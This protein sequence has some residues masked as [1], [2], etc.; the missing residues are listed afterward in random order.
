MELLSGIGDHHFLNEF[1]RQQPA[2]ATD[3]GTVYVA[4]RGRDNDLLNIMPVNASTL[5]PDIGHDFTQSGL[6]TDVGPAL[7]S[8]NGNDLW[9]AWTDSDDHIKIDEVDVNA[10][11]SLSLGADKVTVTD[12][13]HGIEESTD[14]A[15]AL[16]AFN[17]KLYLAWTGE[18][19]VVNIVQLDTNNGGQE[20]SGTKEHFSTSEAGPALG[21]AG[22]QLYLAF[23]GDSDG[24][25]DHLFVGQVTFTGS[26]P[27]VPNVPHVTQLGDELTDDGPALGEF[28]ASRLSLGRAKTTILASCS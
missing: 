6:T 7:A 9:V 10:D 20:V 18:D 4:W 11:G 3:S 26:S 17:G 15:P 22:G 16:A 1:S 8:V 24:G 12:N 27:A 23:T 5:A 28:D 25:T 21:V 2:I 14:S 19:D 13:D